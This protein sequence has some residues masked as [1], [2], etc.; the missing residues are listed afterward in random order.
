L[1][2]V[3]VMSAVL[4]L[5]LSSCGSNGLEEDEGATVVTREESEGIA[6]EYVT[7]SPTFQFDG[8]EETLLLVRTE[9][10]RCPYCW[11]FYFEFDC[12]HSGYGDRT[13]L[14]LA[15]VITPHAARVQVIEGEVTSAVLDDKWDMML[16]RYELR[17]GEEPTAEAEALNLATRTHIT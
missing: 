3:P 1:V 11:E 15:Q 6:R 14:V 5:T 10:L 8:M 17:E 13:G 9:T 12:R 2:A 4:L 7:G 16:Q